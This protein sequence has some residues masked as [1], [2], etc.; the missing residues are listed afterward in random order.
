MEDQRVMRRRPQHRRRRGPR[1]RYGNSFDLV[2]GTLLGFIRR[3]LHGITYQSADNGSPFG[4]FE[5][6]PLGLP[7]EPERPEEPYH[8]G[9][10]G[11]ILVA[12]IAALLAIVIWVV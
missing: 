4:S 5:D 3:A 2:V 9:L 6:E 12:G 11:I 10:P 8:Y 1:H 7:E